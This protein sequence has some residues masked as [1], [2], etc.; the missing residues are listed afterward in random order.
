MATLIAD[1]HGPDQH[2]GGDNLSQPRVT[3]ALPKRDSPPDGT[4]T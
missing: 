4:G 3:P 2:R 1:K